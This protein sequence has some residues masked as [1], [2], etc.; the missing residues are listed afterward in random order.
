MHTNLA[1][2]KDHGAKKL[3]PKTQKPKALN[4]NNFLPSKQSETSEKARKEKKK[5]WQKGKREKKE[6]NSD[7]PA[8]GVNTTNT[9]KNPK[10]CF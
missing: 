4:A 2:A 5:R 3:K 1:K 9:N 6:A 7:I 10:R 8:T